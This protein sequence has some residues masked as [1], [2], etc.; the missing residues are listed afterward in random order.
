MALVDGECGGW[1]ASVVGLQV[2]LGVVERCGHDLKLFGSAPKI[3]KLGLIVGDKSPTIISRLTHPQPD[4]PPDEQTNHQRQSAEH[5][6]LTLNINLARILEAGPSLKKLS[7]VKRRSQ[8]YGARFNDVH[9]LR[10][11][12]RGELA[13]GVTLS[14]AKPANLKA[15]PCPKRQSRQGQFH[16]DLTPNFSAP[17]AQRFNSRLSTPTDQRAMAN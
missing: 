14:F 11:E 12:I 3:F 17:A 1:M 15:E 4:L 16:G 9:G 2:G 6:G 7:V 10:C 8:V 5:N 13:V